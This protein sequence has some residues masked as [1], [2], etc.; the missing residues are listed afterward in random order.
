MSAEVDLEF[1]HGETWHILFSAKDANGAAIDLTGGF[2]QWRLVGGV[3]MTVST[4]DHIA[5]DAGT[6]GTGTITIP[7][8]LYA[9][10]F[11]P[12]AT[13]KHELKIQTDAFG[14]SVQARGLLTMLPSLFDV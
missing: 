9:T 14:A 3:T 6:G 8:S 7:S 12:G 10:D 5:L 4:D 2:V 11:P 1:H 13:Y